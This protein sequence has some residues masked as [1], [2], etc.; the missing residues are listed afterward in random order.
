[1]SESLGHSHFDKRILITG[2]AGVSKYFSTLFQVINSNYKSNQ[3]KSLPSP[4][5]STFNFIFS[6][7]LVMW[8]CSWF[9]SIQITE[10]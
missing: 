9:E 3:K 2:G 4:S 6:L 5:P 7:L 8:L 10:L 1:M